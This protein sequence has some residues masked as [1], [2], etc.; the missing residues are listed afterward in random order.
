LTGTRL[1]EEP[2][3]VKVGDRV[4]RY[5]VEAPLRGSQGQVFRARRDDDGA[6][7]ALKVLVPELALSE[8]ARARFAPEAV[9]H[10]R[11]SHEGAVRVLDTGSLPG[12][13][14]YLVTELLE[15]RSLAAELAAMRTLSVARACAI[16]RACA[17]TL[18]HAHVEGV[19]HRD[20]KPTNVFLTRDGGVKLLDFGLARV[21]GERSITGPGAMLGTPTYVAPEQTH[22]KAGPPADVYS[23]GCVLFELVTGRPPF[24]GSAIGVIRGHLREPPP[25]LAALA[26]VPVPPVLETLVA[27]MLAKDP[28]ARPSASDV[29][30]QLAAIGA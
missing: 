9:A 21:G 1:R 18:A 28:D 20:V 2:G 4:G 10:R 29:E 17:S 12:D 26:P 8:Q 22:T 13:R 15:G 6:L 25:S 30:R 14:A 23:L 16:A 7:V 11:V 24:L 27:A 3:R 5:V 19:V